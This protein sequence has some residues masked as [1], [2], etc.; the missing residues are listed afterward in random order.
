MSPISC[1]IL[2]GLW[3][4]K[5]IAYLTASTTSFTVTISKGRM[6][7][8]DRHRERRFEQRKALMPGQLR[9]KIDAR[10][11]HGLP[12]RLRD[13]TFCAGQCARECERI[14]LATRITTPGGNTISSHHPG[15]NHATGSTRDFVVSGQLVRR[16]RRHAFT[17]RAR[18]WLGP[19]VLP[20]S[21]SPTVSTY[22]G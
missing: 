11:G 6:G 13:C 5:Q 7:V 8:A 15:A 21:R 14:R 18:I 2:P 17:F 9:H 12:H 4:R 10:T 1:T 3:M 22:G 19:F 16:C 20:S